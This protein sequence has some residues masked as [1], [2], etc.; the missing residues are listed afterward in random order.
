MFPVCKLLIKTCLSFALIVGV[1]ACS[2][3]SVVPP[4][5]IPQPPPVSAEDEDYGQQVLSELVKE[6]PLENNDAYVNRVRDIVDRLAK[7]AHA[8]KEPW[9]VYVLKGDSVVNAAATRGNH[10]FVWT[11]ILLRTTS[12]A[13]L[14]T[15]LAH[16]VG[17]VLAGHTL[18]TSGEEAGQILAQVSGQI[19]SGV[20]GSYGP[21][22]PL[23][24]LAGMLVSSAIEALF[25]N[26]V[27]Q[28]SESE[29]DQ[30]GLFLMA[31]A[32]YDPQDA[33][34]FWAKMAKDPSNGSLSLSFLST[35]PPTE[36]RLAALKLLLPEAMKRYYAGRAT[37]G[38]AKKPVEPSPTGR[39]QKEPKRK[40]PK[41]PEPSRAPRTTEPGRSD[42]GWWVDAEN[43][44]AILTDPDPGSPVMST[45]KKGE[46]VRTEFRLGAWY[47]VSQPAVG[48]VRGAELSPEG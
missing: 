30:I 25:V 11:G 14:S 19:A 17:H 46:R 31:D 36:E 8:D 29:A 44:A 28:Q 12:D 7:A 32:S 48:Y 47:K 18:P 42:A 5:E 41:A 4:G 21:Y 22:S 2:G 13:E 23:A 38:R 26:P 34:A 10:V 45:L 33:T 16:E 20:V 39:G 37:G 35:H 9:H 6:Y 27:S 3:R 15:V 24:D 1:T 43:S 40:Q